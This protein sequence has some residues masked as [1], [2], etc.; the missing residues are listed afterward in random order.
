MKRYEGLFIL[1]T[2][3][4]EEGVIDAE[5]KLDETGNAY[6]DIRVPIE[7]KS[8]DPRRPDALEP[9]SMHRTRHRHCAPAVATVRSALL[10]SPEANRAAK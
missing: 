5:Y 9:A 8:R 3:G 1:N 2:A 7:Q 10:H 6:W 4:K